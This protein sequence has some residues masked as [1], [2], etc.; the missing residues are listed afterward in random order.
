MLDK[1]A[2][3]YDRDEEGKL[4]PQERELVLDENDAEQM[5][6]KGE[7]VKIIPMTRGEIKKLFS[8]VGNDVTNTDRDL[9]G[10]LIRKYCKDPSFTEEEILRMRPALSAAIVNTIF[11]DSGID[12]KRGS[13]R[14]PEE[15][16]EFSKN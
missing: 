6:Y 2:A 12:M 10:E 4:I 3:L 15:E 14:T 13:K 8:E 9:D 1:K 7:K 11:V 16:T 5:K